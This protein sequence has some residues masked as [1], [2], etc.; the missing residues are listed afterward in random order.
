M[1]PRDLLNFF[2]TKSGK[3]IAFGAL[4]ATALIIFSAVRKHNLAADEIGS[5]NP[6]RQTHISPVQTIQFFAAQ[7]AKSADCEQRFEFI[8]HFCN[9][10]FHLRR[11]ENAGFND[12]FFGSVNLA[13]FLDDIARNITLLAGEVEK[14]PH[15]GQGVATG[16]ILDSFTIRRFEAADIF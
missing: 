4:F 16:A 7:A 3:L 11:S 13:N 15:V 5:A 10:L 12:L 8:V 9:Y 2:K 1:K 14:I 6:F